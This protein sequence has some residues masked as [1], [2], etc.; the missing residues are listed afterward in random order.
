MRW[1]ES[2]EGFPLVLVHGIPT[3]PALWRR[4]VPRLSGFRCLAWEMVGYGASI[5][6]GRDR[7]ISVSG[8]ADHL[9]AWLRALDIPRAILVGHDLGGGVVQIAAVRHPGICAGLLLTN[10]ICYDSWPIPSVKAMQA[11]RV[12]VAR[13]PEPALR[14][15][16][17]TLF[18]RGHDVPEQAE[19]A[20]EVH[21]SHYARHGAGEALAR[22]VAALDVAD[23]LAVADALPRLARPARVVWGVA[24]QFQKIVYGERLARDLNATL[25][26]IEGGKHFTPEDH[27]QEIADALQ[28]LLAEIEPDRR[29]SAGAEDD[30]E[31][32]REALAGLGEVLPEDASPEVKEI[33]D[34]IQAVL[35]VPFANFLFRVMARDP[36]YLQA[37]WAAVRPVATSR[38]FEAA[39]GELRDALRAAGVKRPDA[40]LELPSQDAEKIRAFTESID[41]ALPKLLIIATLLESPPEAGGEALASPELP[42]GP[43]EGT[44]KAPMVDPATADERLRALFDDIAER[45]GHPAVAT[46]FRSLAQWPEVL[47]GLWTALRP[48][49]GEE[50][51]AAARERLVAEAARL[52]ED[53]PASPP[54]APEALGRALLFFRRRLIPDLM[55]DVQMARE[56][57]SEGEPLARNRFQID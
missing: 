54:R 34:D 22:Q 30:L 23:T 33:Y 41:Y 56:A 51:F 37:G 7:D 15:M 18:Q 43:A 29:E 4:V 48:N 39:A 8:Q 12:I 21:W 27:P 31:A 25:V 20:Q 46:Y 1:E 17:A 53:M 55:L 24:D 32:A 47:E 10:A 6:Q 19:A 14:A 42:P 36:Q 38:R 28:D 50:R 3:S 52:A 16:I 5:P 26:R 57:M 11:T 2:G 40:I 9:A 13:T 44:E 49:V 45:H 35:R